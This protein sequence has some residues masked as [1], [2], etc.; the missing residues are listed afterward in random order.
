MQEQEQTQQSVAVEAIKSPLS[1]VVEQGGSGYPDSA[2]LPHCHEIL[3]HAAGKN[4]ALRSR[5]S[6]PLGSAVNAPPGT[7]LA[8]AQAAGQSRAVRNLSVGRSGE[9]MLNVAYIYIYIYII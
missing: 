2:R 7:N 5:R 1:L 6:I 4:A 9:A 3:L 8:Q